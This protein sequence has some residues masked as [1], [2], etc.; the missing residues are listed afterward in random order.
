MV[1]LL[2]TKAKGIYVRNVISENKIIWNNLKKKYEKLNETVVLIRINIKFTFE[3]NRKVQEQSVL[4]S[5]SN[6]F[7]NR[8]R[9]F[10]AKQIIS[11]VRLI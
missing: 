9:K 11:A 2:T 1:I 3:Q 4:S 8:K 10:V 7:R 5:S 6:Y